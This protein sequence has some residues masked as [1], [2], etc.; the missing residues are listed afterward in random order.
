MFC[1]ELIFADPA[2]N[3]FTDIGSLKWG[4]RPGQLAKW[5]T[6]APL[7]PD[8]QSCFAAILLDAD[9]GELE[10]KMVSYETVEKLMALPIQKLIDDGRKKTCYSLED[11][12]NKNPENRTKFP[13][14][15]RVF[16]T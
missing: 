15:A 2:K 6:I 14:L 5:E 1:I 12:F 4:N 3:A 7:L 16:K 11:V 10:E 8:D 9:G 13:G